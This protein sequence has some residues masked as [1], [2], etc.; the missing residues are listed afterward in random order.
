MVYI[1]MVVTISSDNKRIWAIARDGY[2]CS[3]FGDYPTYT[4]HRYLMDNYPEVKDGRYDPRIHE[5]IIEFESEE[6][7]HWFLLKVT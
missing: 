5:Y 7:Y 3:S 6:H 1:K 4:F 2:H